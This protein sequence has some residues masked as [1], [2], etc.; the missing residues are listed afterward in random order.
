MSRTI[1]MVAKTMPIDQLAYGLMDRTSSALF[2]SPQPIPLHPHLSNPGQK[3][4]RAGLVGK[5][6]GLPT[7][8]EWKLS[9]MQYSRAPPPSGEN[10]WLPFLSSFAAQYSQSILTYFA[11]FFLSG[12]PQHAIK[13]I[14]SC[15]ALL[16]TYQK[17]HHLPGVLSPLTRGFRTEEKQFPSSPAPWDILRTPHSIH[18]DPKHSSSSLLHPL[19]YEPFFS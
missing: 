14:F 1:F 19:H 9:H 10:G 6:V 11:L 4:K 5:G 17:L 12:Y 7:T 3:L 2:P 16:E 18:S 15:T 8:D 13:P